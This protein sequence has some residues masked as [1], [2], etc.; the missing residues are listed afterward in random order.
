MTIRA[1]IFTITGCKSPNVLIIEGTAQSFLVDQIQTS[2]SYR[3]D[4]QQDFHV[5]SQR[6]QDAQV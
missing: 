3:L 1:S 4:S 6:K 5:M 2:Q